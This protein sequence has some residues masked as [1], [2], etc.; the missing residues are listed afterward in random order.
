VKAAQVYNFFNYTIIKIIKNEIGFS[1]MPIA[2]TG[3]FINKIGDKKL[4]KIPGSKYYFA[5]AV[6]HLLPKHCTYGQK[7]SS[8]TLYLLFGI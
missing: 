4:I 1:C 6:L 3:S 8:Y 7:H 5:G 2:M